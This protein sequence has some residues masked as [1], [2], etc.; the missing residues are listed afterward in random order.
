MS[1]SD[2]SDEQ[3]NS[4]VAPDGIAAELFDHW[5]ELCSQSPAADGIPVRAQVD[6]LTL[7]TRILPWFFLHE[8]RDGRY[9]TVIAGTKLVD[10]IGFEPKGRFLDELM[11][12]ATYEIRRCLFDACLERGQPFFYRT[13]LD[14]P[15][16]FHV[17][18]C[19]LVLPLRRTVDGPIDMLFGIKRLLEKSALNAQEQ[20][21]LDSGFRDLL[22]CST[23]DNGRWHAWMADKASGRPA[24]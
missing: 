10:G 1:E 20:W 3:M 5:L 13:G 24:V 2:T 18:A 7:P 19:R 21:R 22:L 15:S 6:M 16:S 23:F 4:G 8:W 12:E 14:N 17:A 9:Q 11:P